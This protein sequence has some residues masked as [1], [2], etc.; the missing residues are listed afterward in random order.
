[1][2]NGFKKQHVH[3]FQDSSNKLFRI[4]HSNDPAQKYI[5]YFHFIPRMVFKCFFN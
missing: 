1:M 2:T 5:S 3:N 4:N